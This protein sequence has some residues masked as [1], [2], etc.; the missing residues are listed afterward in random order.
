MWIE[1]ENTKTRQTIYICLCKN[2][3][4]L[5]SLSKRNKLDQNGDDKHG[6]RV[7]IFPALLLRERERGKMFYSWLTCF[8]MLST[9]EKKIF[10][11]AW[12]LECIFFISRIIKRIQTF[13]NRIE[14]IGEFVKLYTIDRKEI[15]CIFNM[16]SMMSSK[17]YFGI[18]FFDDTH[19]RFVS[20]GF[21]IIFCFL[22]CWMCVIQNERY[23]SHFNSIDRTFDVEY[24]T[25][26]IQQ[27]FWNFVSFHISISVFFFEQRHQI[28]PAGRKIRFAI[29]CVTSKGLKY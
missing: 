26:A 7:K 2:C 29:K 12:E 8:R 5:H 1:K 23:K 22:I 11:T 19:S 27:S 20:N 28:E 10:I 16:C 18:R 24:D 9:T 25:C 4:Y 3:A 6:G 14:S 21:V 15:A 17:S 13:Q